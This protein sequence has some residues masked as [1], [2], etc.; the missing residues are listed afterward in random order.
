MNDRE[1][2]SFPIIASIVLD[3]A[4]RKDK[5]L[6]QIQN[7]LK[8]TLWKFKDNNT[9]IFMIH[10]QQELDQVSSRLSVHN[11]SVTTN[12]NKTQND[13]TSDLNDSSSKRSLQIFGG[14]GGGGGFS[15][16]IGNANDVINNAGGGNNNASDLIGG[17][18]DV[19][20]NNN[21]NNETTD[22]TNAGDGGD[23]TDDAGAQDDTSEVDCPA[24]C[25]TF[26]NRPICANCPPSTDDTPTIGT[27]GNE[28]SNPS[29]ET[30]ET[31]KFH[32]LLFTKKC[33]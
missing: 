26:P 5:K 33:V 31:C 7:E 19:I 16:L 29:N 1:L 32:S 11:L 14:G 4:D 13:K 23:A 9:I 6:S 2:D 28:T 12:N 8:N 15:D 30:L 17:V 27:P 3:D 22:D 18:S 24:L 21:Q 10:N 20:N 25:N